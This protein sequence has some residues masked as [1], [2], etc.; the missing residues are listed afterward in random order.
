M[1][2]EESYGFTPLGHACIKG[3][4]EGLVNLKRLQACSFQA[5]LAAQ[6]D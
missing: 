4:S 3:L 6:D 1:T 2:P 5:P